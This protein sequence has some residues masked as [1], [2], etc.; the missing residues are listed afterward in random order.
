MVVAEESQWRE[1]GTAQIVA[2]A[3]VIAR[4]DT[5]VLN[6]RIQNQQTP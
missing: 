3:R 6:V 4:V 1:I 2:A 5:N